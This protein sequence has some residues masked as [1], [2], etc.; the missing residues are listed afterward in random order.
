MHTRSTDPCREEYAGQLE[1]DLGNLS[2]LDPAP[3]DPATFSGAL[4]E[5]A[6]AEAARGMMQSM[7]NKLFSLPA[8][9][10]R[11]GRLAQLP[12][13]S[14]VLPRFQPM[15]KGKP[16]T[17]WQKCVCGCVAWNARARGEEDARAAG[18]HA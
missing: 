9:P 6:L 14:T 2:A 16:M 5:E 15:P 10:T 7:S 18:C 13:P 12:P 1:F 17:K 3:V 4:R 8:E 11:G